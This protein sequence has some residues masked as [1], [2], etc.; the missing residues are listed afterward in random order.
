L[1]IFITFENKHNNKLHDFDLTI[2]YEIFILRDFFQ[3]IEDQI[4]PKYFCCRDL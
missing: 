2:E 4:V 3:K 1:G